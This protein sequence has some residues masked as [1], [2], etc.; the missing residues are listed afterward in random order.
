V[1]LGTVA[2]NNQTEKPVRLV[3]YRINGV[4]YWIATDRTVLT[5]EQIAKIYELGTS[6]SFLHGGN[7][8]CECT[9]S[10]QEA[11]TN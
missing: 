2:D 11:N 6:K 5:A 8:T 3:G 4:D 1:L 10:L 9:T 7:V